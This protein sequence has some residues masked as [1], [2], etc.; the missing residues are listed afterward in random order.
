MSR[1]AAGGKRDAARWMV[2]MLR[3]TD[4]SFYTGITSDLVRRLNAHAAGTASRYT[5]ARRPLVLVYLESAANRRAAMRRELQIKGLSR[6]RKEKLV[7]GGRGERRS[8]STG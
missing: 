5:R 4:G 3:C 8:K 7:D 1:K 6:I 2:Y